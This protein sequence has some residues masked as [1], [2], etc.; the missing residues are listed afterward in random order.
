MSK[1]LEIFRK[2]SIKEL[3]E[4]RTNLI[5]DISIK[6]FTYKGGS[7]EMNIVSKDTKVGLFG[8]RYFGPGL[9]N[10]IKGF[11]P[12]LDA[13][14]EWVKIKINPEP[15]KINSISF[16]I[17]RAIKKRG[18]L[19]HQKKRKPVNVAKETRRVT[20]IVAKELAGEVAQLT[21]KNIINKFKT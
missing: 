16:L 10:G 2:I 4:S 9:V 3:K 15:K 7:R 13:L 19:L 1:A 17:G 8:V 21:V 14:R 11:F 18:T 6:K 20:K 12:K 5:K